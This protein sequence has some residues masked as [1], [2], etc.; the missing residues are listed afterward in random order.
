M[1]AFFR[2]LKLFLHEEEFYMVVA[3]A[4]TSNPLQATTNPLLT[5]C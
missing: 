2:W 3:S 5:H 1:F 4:H